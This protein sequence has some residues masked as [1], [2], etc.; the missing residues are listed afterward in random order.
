MTGIRQRIGRIAP[1]D[2]EPFVVR[3]PASWWPEV[4]LAIAFA[5]CTVLASFHSPLIDLDIWIRDFSDAHRPPWFDWFLVQTNKLGQ[6]GFLSGLALGIAAII[7]YV[8]QTVRPVVA[9]FGAY[10]LTALVL[11]LKLAFPRIY[12]HWPRP[13]PGP[14][15][16]AAQ[17]LLYWPDRSELGEIGDT[18]VGAYPSGHVVNT[19]IWYGLLV[20]LTG[21]VLKTWQRRLLLS[22]PVAIVFFS[23]TYLGFHWLTDSIAGLFMGMVLIRVMQRVHWTTIPLP[24][25]LEPERR[26]RRP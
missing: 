26:Y 17:S 5:A 20:M 18:A 10:V 15:A 14:F 25:W 7:G 9:F 6:G 13:D 8:K 16:N 21:A 12:P 3:R 19:L 11:V 2:W 1:G 22:A 4:L 23:T 24:L